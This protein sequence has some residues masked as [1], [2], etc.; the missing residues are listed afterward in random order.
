MNIWCKLSHVCQAYNVVFLAPDLSDYTFLR[1]MSDIIMRSMGFR[2]ILVQNESVSAALGAG[3]SGACIVDMGASSIK[4]SCIEDGWL[5]PD[6]RYA[7]VTGSEV[8]FGPDADC[9]VAE[10]CSTTEETT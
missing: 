3:L 6:T 8:S 5:M 4:I 9:S 7:R 2:A 10:C 1:S